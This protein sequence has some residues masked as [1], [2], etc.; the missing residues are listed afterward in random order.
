M[1]VLS[2]NE[3]NSWCQEIRKS[4]DPR[5]PGKNTG[6][7]KEIT[8]NQ[9]EYGFSLICGALVRQRRRNYHPI[10]NFLIFFLKV[11]EKNLVLV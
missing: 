1:A 7:H 4:L 6:I 9:Q 8:R 2:K 3:T 11:S 10:F 5:G